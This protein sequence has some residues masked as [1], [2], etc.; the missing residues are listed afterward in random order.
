MK[1]TGLGLSPNT[2]SSHIYKP[3]LLAMLPTFRFEEV[4]QNLSKVSGRG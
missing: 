4:N 3:G 2:I 1:K